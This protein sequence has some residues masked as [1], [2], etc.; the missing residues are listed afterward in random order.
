[1]G[2]LP[3]PYPS[4]PAS[5]T[6][7]NPDMILP[8]YDLASSPGL[9]DE[10]RSQSPL[11]MWKNAHAAA[12]GADL[13]QLFSVGQSHHQFPTGP[14]TPTT[15][16][17]YG[18]GTMLS[19]IGEVTEAESTPGKPS[20]GSIRRRTAGSAGEINGTFG[21]SA[22]SRSPSPTPLLHNIRHPFLHSLHAHGRDNVEDAI[23]RSSPTMG[24]EDGLASAAGGKQ[25]ARHQQQQH[26]SQDRAR[27]ESLE[28]NS[29]ITTQD[30]AGLFADFDD[31][32]SVG[33]SV[34]Q[35]DDEESVAESYVQQ[36]YVQHEVTIT[37]SVAPISLLAVPEFIGGGGSSSGGYT[38]DEGEP[39]RLSA[40]TLSLRAEKILANAKKRLTV[41]LYDF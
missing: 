4:L 28:S 2:S 24:V 36:G 40:A 34:F 3:Q 20:P 35:G 33:D 17:I 10:V 39:R 38:S 29:T 21:S 16:I 15:P 31:T 6:L 12:S 1:M 23:R 14:I 32:I 5:P 18:N 41:S 37:S 26:A 25:R 22:R 30:Q 9:D 19:D 7:T 13:Q 27:R 8:D 11:M